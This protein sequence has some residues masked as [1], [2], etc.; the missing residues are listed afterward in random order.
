MSSFVI[1]ITGPESC[2][3]TT[4]ASDLATLLKT[5]YIKEYAVEY[6][7]D[8]GKSY[9]ENDVEIIA[10]K[11]FSLINQS[12]YKV[13][14]ADS[15]VLVTKIW[16]EFKYGTSSEL[17][18]TLW[19]KQQADLYVLTYPDVEWEY[20]EL[21]ENPH[22]RLQLFEMYEHALIE[23]MCKFVIV[24]GSRTERIQTVLEYLRK[25]NIVITTS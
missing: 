8:K 25:Q 4:L 18:N 24:Y 5:N 17:I 3:K 6:L 20:D 23:K 15:D 12:E 13:V 14:I 22:N 1:A 7:K 11:Q 21:R 9:S 2:G 16:Y 10:Q 19:D